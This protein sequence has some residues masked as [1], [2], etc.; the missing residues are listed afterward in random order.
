MTALR[1]NYLQQISS[2][3][4]LNYLRLQNAKSLLSAIKTPEYTRFVERQTDIR[5]Y[6]AIA[7]IFLLLA[8]F[9]V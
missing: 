6:Y 9:A 1:E 5:H 8:L 2:E 7:V 4:G 3:T